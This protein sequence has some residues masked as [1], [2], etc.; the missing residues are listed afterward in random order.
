M[1][2]KYSGMVQCS[3][4]MV[5]DGASKALEA[6]EECPGLLGQLCHSTAKSGVAVWL[7]FLISSCCILYTFLF[8]AFCHVW[9]LP[10]AAV[11]SANCF[12]ELLIAVFLLPFVSMPR[13]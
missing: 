3:P 13:F 10:G 9:Q 5:Q 1:L 2:K 11:Q 12:L 7:L 8:P 4:S 6:E